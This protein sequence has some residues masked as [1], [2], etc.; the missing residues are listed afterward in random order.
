MGKIILFTV[1]SKYLFILFLFAR[2]PVVPWV[3]QVELENEAF[4]YVYFNVNLGESYI[5]MCLSI[6]VSFFSI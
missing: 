1:Y 6:P 5:D 3:L 2:D 4:R